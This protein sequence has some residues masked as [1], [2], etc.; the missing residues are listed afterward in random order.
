[1]DMKIKESVATFSTRGQLV[2][3]LDVRKHFG[4]EDGTKALVSVVDGRIVLEP[5][6]REYVRSRF[7]KYKGKNLLASLAAEK[8]ME[9]SR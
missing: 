2:I 7:G 8:S 3:P 4:I 5:L 9:K 1:M 6:T